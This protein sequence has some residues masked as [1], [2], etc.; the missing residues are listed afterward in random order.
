MLKIIGY[1][2]ANITQSKRG[3]PRIYY[4]GHDY[5]FKTTRGEN[6]IWLC[7]SSLNKRRCTASV[8][9][10]YI[11]DALMMRVKNAKHICE[12]ETVLSL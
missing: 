2:L 11:K 1:M 6:T 5:G 12:G 8:E 7:T 3:Y 9:S 4:N 10:K